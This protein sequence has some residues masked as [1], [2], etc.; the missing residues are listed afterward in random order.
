MIHL[1]SL[2]IIYDANSTDLSV[3]LN[4]LSIPDNLFDVKVIKNISLHSSFDR[5]KN[6]SIIHL[7][8]IKYEFN[9]NDIMYHFNSVSNFI[10]DDLYQ[11]KKININSLSLVNSSANT[12]TLDF[13]SMIDLDRKSMNGQ[14]ETKNFSFYNINPARSFVDINSY[15]LEEYILDFNLFEVSGIVVKAFDKM[16]GQCALSFGSSL[17][18]YKIRFTPIFITDKS[19]VGNITIPEINDIKRFHYNVNSSFVNILKK[20]KLDSIQ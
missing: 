14:I 10:I 6:R 3:K 7:N 4:K 12:E 15:D 9:I 19:Y 17:D 16:S 5:I 2:N 18:D 20:N 13:T 11:L 8:P 1:D